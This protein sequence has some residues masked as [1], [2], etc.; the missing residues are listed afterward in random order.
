MYEQNKSDIDIDTNV[1]TTVSNRS[2]GSI[3]RSGH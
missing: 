2:S 1:K 3:K